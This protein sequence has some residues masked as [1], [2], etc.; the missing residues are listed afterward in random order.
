VTNEEGLTSVFT[1]GP[2]FEILA[3]NPSEEYTLSTIAVSKKQL[4]LRTEKFLY[5]IGK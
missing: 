3:E 5:A 4:F 2:K 1:A